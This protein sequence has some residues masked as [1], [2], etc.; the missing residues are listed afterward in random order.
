MNL[1]LEESIL[2]ALKEH[3]I[4]YSAILVLIH[5]RQTIESHPAPRNPSIHPSLGMVKI[6]TCCTSAALL[7]LGWG[8][9]TFLLWSG[10]ADWCRGLRGPGQTHGW[11]C[12]GICLLV[13]ADI[14]KMCHPVRRQCPFNTV[15]IS[16][17]SSLSLSVYL[18]VS[19]IGCLI[20]Q[21]LKIHSLLLYME[22]FKT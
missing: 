16:G 14:Y 21:C 17:R 19:L 11:H 1:N 18:S 7:G 9:E 20:W 8:C 4:Y 15:I 13:R 22:R 12:C 5:V 10:R 6:T 2:S 3:W